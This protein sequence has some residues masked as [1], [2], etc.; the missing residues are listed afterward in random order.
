VDGAAGELER[1]LAFYHASIDPIVQGL[2][3]SDDPW[4]A[5]DAVVDLRGRVFAELE[6]LP[7]GGQVFTAWADLED[8]Y[9]MGKTPIADAHA[10]LRAAAAE[11]LEL[12]SEALGIESWIQRATALVRAISSRDGTF[13]HPSNHD[14]PKLEWLS[15][16]SDGPPLRAALARLVDEDGGRD[17]AE[18]EYFEA[19]N[20][21]QFRTNETAQRRFRS[22]MRRRLR[23]RGAGED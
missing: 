6:W 22:Q 13:W 10:A 20:D 9:D 18:N 17:A 2:L 19:A 3:G 21:P 1:E 12:S 7:H 5:Y 4:G 23:H 8:I 16:L 14:S 11:W 15:S